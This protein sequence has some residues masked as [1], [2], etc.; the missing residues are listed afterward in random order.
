MFLKL[1]LLG[2]FIVSWPQLRSVHIKQVVIAMVKIVI[3]ALFT[4]GYTN[5]GKILFEISRGGHLMPQLGKLRLNPFFRVFTSVV[6]FQ[7]TGQ[8]C[9]VYKMTFL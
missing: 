8:S 3:G 1:E 7:E 9:R 2:L 6:D 5:M 4:N